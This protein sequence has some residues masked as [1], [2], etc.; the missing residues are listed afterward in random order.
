MLWGKRMWSGNSRDG[1]K[2]PEMHRESV[3]CDS[4][5]RKVSVVRKC[6]QERVALASYRLLSGVSFRDGANSYRVAACSCIAPHA[7]RCLS[8]FPSGQKG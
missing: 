5:G 6:G 7:L 3:T 2:L 1:M 4:S 8:P